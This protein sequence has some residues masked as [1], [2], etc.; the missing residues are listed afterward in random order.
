MEDFVFHEGSPPFDYHPDFEYTLFNKHAHLF[1]QDPEGWHSYSI[2]NKKYK[3]I[4][5]IFFVNI[6]EGVARS[7]LKSP[8]GSFEVSPHLSGNILFEFVDFV[9]ARLKAKQVE[10]IVIKD[11]PACYA[12]ERAALLHTF[13]FNLGYHVCDAEVGAVITITE[14]SFQ[15]YPDSWERRKLRQAHDAGVKFKQLDLSELTEVYLFILASRKQRGYSLSMSLAEIKKV[16]DRFPEEYL[17]FGA[18]KDGKL[19]AASIAIR[20]RENILYNFY[21]AHSQEFD[22][23]SPVVALIEGIYQFC[24]QEKI[25]MLDLGTSAVDGK[26]NF[27]LLDFKLRLGSAATPKLTFQKNF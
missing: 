26:P 17:L 7:P 2:L 16:V 6:K 24:Q 22:H 25:E 18:Y 8:F 11:Q 10:N 20:V 5:A 27:G 21:S 15:C 19:A 14:N 1:L 13:L 12:P 4:S 23:L 9:T 3:I